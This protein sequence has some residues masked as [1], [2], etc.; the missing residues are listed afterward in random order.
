MG[1]IGFPETLVIL[2]IVFLVFGTKKLPDLAR[3]L[4]QAIRGFKDAVR[5]G[6]EPPTT[7][8][9]VRRPI[10]PQRAR[11]M[12][13]PATSASKRGIDQTA[14]PPVTPIVRSRPRQARVARRLR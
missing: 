1:R 2:A 5:E 6:E 8:P 9:P 11:A 4:G 14:R 13:V 10:R 7:K 3:G 12:M